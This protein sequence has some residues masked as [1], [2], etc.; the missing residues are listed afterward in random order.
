MKF[1]L[2]WSIVFA[3][4]VS[5]LLVSGCATR[6]KPFSIVVLPDTQ[7]YA[8]VR[9]ADAE[10]Y[11]HNGDL[12]AYFFAQTN[13]IKANKDE[14]NIKMVLQLGDLVQADDPREYEIADRALSIIEDVVPYGLCIG[15]HDMGFGKSDKHSRT[16]RETNFNDFFPPSRFQNNPLYDYGGNLDDVSD[17]YYL[18]FKAGGMKFLVLSFEFFPRDEVLVW[19]NRVVSDHP[20]HRVIMFTHCF[21]S[22]DG[23]LNDF[24]NYPLKGN[25]A[26]EMWEEFVKQHKN[27]FLVLSGHIIG[28]ATVTT[29]G[30]HGNNVYQLLADYQQN[31]NGGEGYLRIMTFH[32]NENRIDVTSYSPAID[33]S[34][35]DHENQFSLEY[36]MRGE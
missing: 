11:W 16:S 23:S 15:N 21:L 36:E 33:E 25:T 13:W 19:A 28:E 10:N 27:I 35:T 34:M 4:I 18:R 29:K 1:C 7:Y 32:P 26:T 8:D 22:A 3:L 2:H 5:M 31:Y 9:T 12:R 14:M 24:K 30:L 6:A 17:N 20:D